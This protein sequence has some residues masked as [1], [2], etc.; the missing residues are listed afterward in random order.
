M[1]RMFDWY[2]KFME[3]NVTESIFYCEN[4]T[5]SEKAHFVADRY[6]LSAPSKCKDS[7]WL[8]VKSGDKFIYFVDAN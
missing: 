6:G 2:N 4:N 7:K 8:V 3:S 1:K 5:A